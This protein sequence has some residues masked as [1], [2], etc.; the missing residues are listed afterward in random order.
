MIKALS[1]GQTTD[2]PVIELQKLNT[3]A[4]S[5]AVDIVN[6]ALTEMVGRA[7]RECVYRK[8]YPS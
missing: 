8:P 1:N 5:Y 3:A 6:A 7:E 2:I 4:L